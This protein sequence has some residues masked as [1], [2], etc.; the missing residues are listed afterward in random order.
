MSEMMVYGCKVRANA[1]Y[2]VGIDK[3]Q[4]ALFRHDHS[5]I[6]NRSNQ[7]LRSVSSSASF[8]CVFYSGNTNSS[9]ASISRGVRPAFALCS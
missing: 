2:D 7:W 4:L 1:G 6:V 3:E 9:Y 8:A 5:R